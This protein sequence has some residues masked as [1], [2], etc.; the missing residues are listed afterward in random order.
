MINGWNKEQISDAARIILTPLGGVPNVISFTNLN[1]YGD[2]MNDEVIVKTIRDYQSRGAGSTYERWDCRIRDDRLSREL[3]INMVNSEPVNRERRKRS[4]AMALIDSNDSDKQST[5]AGPACLIVVPVQMEQPSPE[6]MEELMDKIDFL[7]RQVAV[8]SDV[9]K[10][11]HQEHGTALQNIEVTQETLAE[12]QVQIADTQV[13]ITNEL[14]STRKDLDA[15]RIECEQKRFA[16]RSQ[17][18]KMSIVSKDRNELR[19]KLAR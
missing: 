2:T 12:K 7:S 11:N 17:A 8:L 19:A 10:N 4:A 9:I 13:S 14:T 3:D 15:S 1:N 6:K 16:K 18:G 5:E